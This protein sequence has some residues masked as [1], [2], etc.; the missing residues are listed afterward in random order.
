M[1]DDFSTATKND[2]SKRVG[3]RC[4]N[5]DCRRTT[6]GP[7]S[8]DAGNVN[9]GVAAHITAAA[10]GGMRFDAAISSMD[11]SGIN[12]G[13]WLCQNCAKLIDSDSTYSVAALQE[14]RSI[15][16]A[17]A[18]LELRGFNVALDRSA[19]WKRKIESTLPDLLSKM[20]KDLGEKSVQRIFFLMHRR[21]SYNMS[22]DDFYYYYDDHPNLRQKVGILENLNLVGDV[23]H[24]SVERFK[25]S[26]MFADYLLE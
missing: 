5:P 15:A 20:R 18:L 1:R 11:R 26:E 24:T 14:W 22:G 4:S 10:S 16:E 19:V 25:M 6:S 21:V 17:A 9:L 12:N 7:T 2:L 23:T 13:I 8:Q 3:L